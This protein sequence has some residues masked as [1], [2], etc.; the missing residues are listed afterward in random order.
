MKIMYENPF[1]QSTSWGFPIQAIIYGAAV[2]D[3]VLTEEQMLIPE[4]DL[5]YSISTGAP[6]GDM[7]GDNISDF[8]GYMCYPEIWF[9]GNYDFSTPNLIIN[10]NPFLDH[11][12]VRYGDFNNDGFD[13]I[14]FGNKMTFNGYGEAFIY[15]GKANPN[16][17]CDL[18]ISAPF[19][20]PSDGWFGNSVAVSDFNH[21]GCDDIAISAPYFGSGWERYGHVYILEG[22]NELTDTTTET[23]DNSIIARP[24][25]FKAY[26]NPFNPSVNFEI[27][28]VEKYKNLSIEIY[29]IKGQK[30]ETVILNS[31][32][33][34]EGKVKHQFKNLP[35]AVYLCRLKEGK[36]T[37]KTQ[38]ITLMK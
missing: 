4:A 38:K 3:T 10:D 23:N 15:L 31:K 6:I 37:L 26:P 11:S 1:D 33:I 7:N 34:A 13:D 2:I 20:T 35:S 9:G 24:V 16:G 19:D 32:A 22:N 36:T 29:N 12:A 28:N 5:V 14:V 17:I 21:D 18:W 25:I 30:L 27:R 8:I